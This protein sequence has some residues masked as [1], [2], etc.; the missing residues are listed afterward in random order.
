MAAEA[1]RSIFLQ[2]MSACQVEEISTALLRIDGKHR[3]EGLSSP[4]CSLLEHTETEAGLLLATSS[5]LRRV[6]L[7]LCVFL[8]SH[9][10]SVILISLGVGNGMQSV[11]DPG[12][13]ECLSS[14]NATY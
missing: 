13:V 9:S 7:C 10:S 2:S 14:Q 11:I 12:L 8:L 4:R 6:Y 3:W 1:V 5:S